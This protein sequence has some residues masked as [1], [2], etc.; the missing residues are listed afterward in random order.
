M[1]AMIC[2]VGG[3]VGIAVDLIYLGRYSRKRKKQLKEINIAGCLCAIYANEVCDLCEGVPIEIC[4]Y[5]W[6]VV[7][8]SGDSVPDDRSGIC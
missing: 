7:L 8:G 4:W 6:Y 5:L 1:Q 2:W 3:I